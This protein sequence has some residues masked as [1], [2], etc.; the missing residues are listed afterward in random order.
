MRRIIKMNRKL[1]ELRKQYYNNSDVRKELISYMK[2]REVVFMDKKDFW[3]CIRLL[4][5]KD[6]DALNWLF[7]WYDFFQEKGR[8]KNNYNIY[9][10]LAK[11]SYIPRFDFN[12]HNRSKETSKFFDQEQYKYITQFDLLLD[13]DYIEDKWIELKAEVY[14]I[15]WILKEYGICFSVFP[16]GTG[17]QIIIYSEQISFIDNCLSKKRFYH[18]AT[19]TSFNY[20][21]ELLKLSIVKKYKLKFIC[22]SSIKSL[23]KIRK[24]EYSLVDNRICFPLDIEEILYFNYAQVR[25]DKINKYF[26]KGIIHNEHNKYNCEN[27]TNFLKKENIQVKQ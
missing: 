23:T 27:F 13:F 2:D 19:S 21:I 16:S 18:T 1:I 24:C 22:K 10:S 15:A 20:N 6:D 14:Q 9:V 25:Y 3:K 12:L 7:S 8:S 11:Y 4:F 17:F 5:V 26:R